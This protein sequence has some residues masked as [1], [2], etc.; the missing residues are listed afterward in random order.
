[1]GNAG[2]PSQPQIYK[3]SLW[4]VVFEPIKELNADFA[5]F[6]AHLT[7]EVLAFVKYHES[8]RQARLQMALT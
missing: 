2:Q 1:L 4:K 6:V 3:Q 8:L 7:I 5:R